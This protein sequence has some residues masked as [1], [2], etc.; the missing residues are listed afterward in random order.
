M[1]KF[2]R[3]KRHTRQQQNLPQKAAPDMKRDPVER[4]AFSVA[5]RLRAALGHP[6]TANEHASGH[7]TVCMTGHPVLASLWL[8]C[9]DSQPER[10]LIEASRD[11]RNMPPI[12]SRYLRYDPQSGIPRLPM[13]LHHGRCTTINLVTPLWALDELRWLSQSDSGD[14]PR[15]LLDTMLSQLNQGDM[16]VIIRLSNLINLLKGAIEN[17]T[18]A[19][20]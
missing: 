1:K 13:V 18:S 4:L 16:P 7:G 8:Q 9:V 6:A 17:S 10:A 12:R 15:T 14:A 20:Y 5:R 19:A 11:S 2:T 3:T